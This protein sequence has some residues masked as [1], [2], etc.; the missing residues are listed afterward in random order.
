VDRGPACGGTIVNINGG[1]NG[2]GALTYSTLDGSKT[3][4]ASVTYG[5]LD[6]DFVGAGAKAAEALVQEVF[7]D[8]RTEG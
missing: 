1:V 3:V 8:G 2:Y 4:S 5:H 6:F 7:C